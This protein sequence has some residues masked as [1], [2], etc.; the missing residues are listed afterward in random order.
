MSKIQFFV[1]TGSE[2][3]TLDQLAEQSWIWI[4]D[5]QKICSLVIG[6]CLG[7]MLIGSPP[8][9]EEN[10]SRHWLQNEIFS[11]GLENDQ[12]EI[13][14]V[15]ELSYSAT[16]YSIE[17]LLITLENLPP[18]VQT[19]CR[20]AF[21]LPCQY[22][23]ACAIPEEKSESRNELFE[24]LK[25]SIE[26]ESWEF[27]EEKRLLDIVSQCFL[28]TLLKQTCMLQKSPSHPAMDEIFKCV[29]N[30][31]QKMINLM[32][33]SKYK[34]EEVIYDDDKDLE[35]VSNTL[36]DANSVIDKEY[37]FYNSCQDILQRCL[38][39][40]IYVRGKCFIIIFI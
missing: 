20:V 16:S 36:S 6:H 17:P 38:F 29:L 26:G 40:L 7:G 24:K 30:L 2:T 35:H 8:T 3:P 32:C 18:D 21:D 11:S 27:E 9:Q 19:L 23:E 28:I 22:D 14:A 34:T 39:L 1:V 33:S 12:I 37:N 4:V 15:V 13:A 25:E 10:L 5:M 31:R